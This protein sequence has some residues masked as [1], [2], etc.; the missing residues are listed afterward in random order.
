MRLG[1]GAA[2]I[3]TVVALAPALLLPACIADR[4]AD[5]SRLTL[6]ATTTIQD[7]GLLDSLVSAFGRSHPGIRLRVLTAGT[8]EALEIGRRGDADVLLTHDPPAESAFVA[9]GHGR[10]RREVM[11]NDFV[12]AGPA[13]DP[14]GVRG[15]RDGPAALARIAAAASPF[16]SRGDD[17]GTHRKEIALWKGVGPA[18]PGAARGPWYIEAGL[19]MGEALQLAAERDAYVL[20]DRA[21]YLTI[22][23]DLRL[24]ILVEGD[25]RMVNRYGV[26]RVSRGRNAAGA[27]AFAGWI[28]GADGQATIGAFGRERFGRPLFTPAVPER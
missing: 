14:A 24:D 25:P 28:T 9:A 17:S 16:V 3:A 6:V 11:H 13:A 7:S 15:L 10:D 21:T 26:T 23:E 1:E 2:R 18:H 5:P 4:T 8:G 20:T 22:R 19:G 27:L 12:I